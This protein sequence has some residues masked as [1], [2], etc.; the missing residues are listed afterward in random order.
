MEPTVSPFSAEKSIHLTFFFSFPPRHIK[1]E[2]KLNKRETFI[3][4]F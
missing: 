2:F 3:Y 4:I 1:L